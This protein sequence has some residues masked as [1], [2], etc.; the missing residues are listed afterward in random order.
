MNKIIII[1]IIIIIIFNLL[2]GC[3][4]GY[5]GIDSNLMAKAKKTAEGAKLTEKDKKEM[6]RM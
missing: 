3:K 4:E 5:Q 1:F 6:P 2:Y